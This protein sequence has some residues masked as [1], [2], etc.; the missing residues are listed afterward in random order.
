MYVRNITLGIIIF[1]II[2]IIYGKEAII[3]RCGRNKLKIEPQQAKNEIPINDFS[4]YYK[5][6]LDSDGFKNFSIYLDFTNIEKDIERYNLNNYKNLFISSFD[7]VINTLQTLLKVKPFIYGYNFEDEEIEK[8]GIN[9]WHKEKFWNE[10][11][12]KNITTKTLG[13]DLIIFGRF[14]NSTELGK[15]TLAS[16]IAYYYQRGTGQP[17]VGLVNINKDVNYSLIHSQEYFQSIILHEFTHI[18]GFDLYYFVVFFNNL[19]I[20]KD[21]YGIE[22]YYINST[23]VVNTAKKY[24]NCNN[25]VG[26]ELENDGDEG[27]AG[28]HWEGRI[29]LGDYMNGAIYTE[30]QA[31]SEITL[32]LLEDMGYYKANYYTG[33]LM[34][35]GKNKG[36]DFLDE[37][38]VNYFLE[39]NPK[40]ENEFFDYFNQKSIFDPSCSSGR[41]SRTYNLLWRYYSR[42]P[43]RYIYYNNYY[44]GGSSSADYTLLHQMILM[45]EI[46]DIL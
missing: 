33:G 28:S 1:T 21:K 46:M 22:R 9:Y 16:A 11:L 40:F 8:M 17:I 2:N 24:F 5:R 45:K 3:Y 10:A 25:L 44:L 15:G 39:I 29:L 27:T 43:L 37:K 13:I 12:K 7:K 4:S 6:K 14:A 26:V 41:Q 23:R 20:K 34:R 18:L 32:A 38:C 19:L 35:Y 30:E 42:I 36:C 31:I